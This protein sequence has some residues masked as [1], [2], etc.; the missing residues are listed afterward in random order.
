MEAVIDIYQRVDAR[1][2]RVTDAAYQIYDLLVSPFAVPGAHNS[3]GIDAL[4]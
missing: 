2:R 4:S 3:I 1:K